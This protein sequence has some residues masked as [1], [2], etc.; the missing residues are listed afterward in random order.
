M[1]LELRV[2]A[3]G[4]GAAAVVFGK[5]VEVLPAAAPL[6]LGVV[7]RLDDHVAAVTVE[8]SVFHAHNE[9]IEGRT[10]AHCGEGSGCGGSLL[11]PRGLAGFVFLIPSVER[12]Q[13]GGL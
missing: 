11:P 4:P 10:S 9:L 7:E 12:G 1:P 6:W 5:E 3:D 13:C 2:L 8:C